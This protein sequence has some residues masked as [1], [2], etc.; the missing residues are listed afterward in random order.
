M[1]LLFEGGGQSRGKHGSPCSCLA[2][3]S[4]SALRGSFGSCGRFLLRLFRR[5][6]RPKSLNRLMP[7]VVVPG[8][9]T[10]VVTERPPRPRLSNGLPALSAIQVGRHCCSPSH[11][12][13][14]CGLL[15][16]QPKLHQVQLR[17][18]FARPVLTFLS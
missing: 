2:L 16:Q 13:R 4:R 10:T 7:A 18:P 11:S 15:F 1:L 8:H 3:P 14:H 12:R 5:L 6:L 17:A 9:S